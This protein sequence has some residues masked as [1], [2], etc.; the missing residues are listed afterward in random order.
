MTLPNDCEMICFDCGNLFFSQGNYTHILQNEKEMGEVC[1]EQLIRKINKEE[2]TM[3]NVVQS[4]L[5]VGNSTKC[6]P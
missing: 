5:I 1:V 4:N 6:I 3:R 2:N